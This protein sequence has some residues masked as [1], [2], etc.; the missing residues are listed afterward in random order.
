MLRLAF[1]SILLI[2]GLTGQLALIGDRAS[3]FV[4][5]AGA[6]LAILGLLSVLRPRARSKPA[7]DSAAD[8]AS[9]PLV[10]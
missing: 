7:T 8:S 10:A 1:G 3:K 2:S 5:L 4:A 6:L 9:K